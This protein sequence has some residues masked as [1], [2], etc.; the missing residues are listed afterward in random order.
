MAAK[1]K[2]ILADD[3]RLFTDGL[4]AMLKSEKDFEIVGVMVTG[5]EVLDFIKQNQTDIA[6]RDINMPGLN[7]IEAA[8]KLRELRPE[9][10]IIALTTHDDREHIKEMLRAGASGYVL[11]N[12]TRNELAEAIRTVAGG[13]TYLSKEVK[14]SLMSNYVDQLHHHKENPN[15][16]VIILTP[17][18][19]ELVKLLAK[20]LSNDQIADQLHISVRTVE[21]HRKNVMHKTKSGNLAGLMKYAYDKGLAK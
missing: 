13:N 1:L 10:K 5:Y 4:A 18:E 2:I 16:E 17:R 19:I 15:E 14:D 6:V 20:G 12:A 11:K 8:R 21:T 9:I 3:H 7:G